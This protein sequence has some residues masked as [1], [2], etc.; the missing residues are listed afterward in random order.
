MI[1]L[2]AARTRTK[3]LHKPGSHFVSLSVAQEKLVTILTPHDKP[4]ELLGLER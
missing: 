2:F 4:C 1:E 3:V